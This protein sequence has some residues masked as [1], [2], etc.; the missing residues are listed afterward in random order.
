MTGFFHFYVLAVMMSLLLYIAGVS[1][2]YDGLFSFLPHWD[3]KDSRYATRVCQCP[4]TGFFISTKEEEMKKV[5]F[6]VSMPYDGLFHFYAHYCQ[7]RIPRR[8][9]VSMPYDGLFHFY[10]P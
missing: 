4:M 6:I 10:K 3:R 5:A 7:R 2:P 8:L 9:R 1:M